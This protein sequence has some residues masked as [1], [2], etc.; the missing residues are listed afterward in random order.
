MIVRNYKEGTLL[1]V[2]NLNK[3]T[4]IFDR[5]ESEFT[6]V[7]HNEWRPHLDG[8]PHFH[9]EKVAAKFPYQEKD[10]NTLRTEDGAFVDR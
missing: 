4:V 6:E 9:D 7:G 5:S 3:I 10:W 1:D 2:A 8:P